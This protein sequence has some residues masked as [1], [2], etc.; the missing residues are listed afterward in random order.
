MLVQPLWKTVW[1]CL[2][3][4]KMELLYDPAISVQGIYLKETKTLCQKDT[5]TPVFRA[6]LF[7]I[8]KTQKQPKCP[9]TD[10]WFKKIRY[11]Y[12]MEYYSAIRKN[13]ILPF[14]A[15]WMDLGTT[16]LSE[17]RHRK[18]HLS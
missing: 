5:C 17:K 3:K 14:A 7:T 12:A 13:E 2:K 1:R 4:L 15:T 16:I 6:A 10:D 18:R 9:S 11:R 8:A